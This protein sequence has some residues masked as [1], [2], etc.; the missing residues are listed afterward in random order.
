MRDRRVFSKHQSK[1]H[2]SFAMATAKRTHARGKR[3]TKIV[4]RTRTS[5]RRKSV[6]KA[7]PK[8][9][10]V[11]GTPS[12]MRT[13]LSAELQAHARR[14]FTETDQPGTEIA[15]DCGV[16]ESVI[17][18]M[19]LREGWVRYVAPP[20]DLPPVAKLLAEV[21]KLEASLAPQD[22]GGGADGPSPP[23]SFEGGLR[24]PPRDDGDR[25]QPDVQKDIAEFEHAVMGYVR[26]FDALRKNG[27]LLPTQH[28]ATARA[29]N[30]L[31]DAFNKLQR[32]R[33]AH[34]PGSTHDDA[35][36]MPADLDEFRDELARRIRAFVASR[37]GPRDADGDSGSAVVDEVR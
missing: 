11:A 26:E 1:H 24:P 13:R 5:A 29:I 23:P 32:M 28:L 31:T 27:M 33:A 25:A 19:A 4:R 12:P 21:E 36:D 18:R 3:A 34:V 22:D 6:R 16:D 17:R 30:T 2:R 14:L 8:G 10:P 15:A 20:R 7:K 9:G 35:T 37:A